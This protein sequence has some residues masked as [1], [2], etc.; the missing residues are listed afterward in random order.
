MWE[1]IEN[2]LAAMPTTDPTKQRYL[3]RVNYYGQQVRMDA[4]GRIILPQILREK[5]GMNG[6]V[7]VSAQLDH[8]VIWNR[9]QIERRLEEEPFT[10]QDLQVLTERGI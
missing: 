9:D 1:E 6:D 8:L 7:V 4:Q 2:R 3:E 10:D 5:A